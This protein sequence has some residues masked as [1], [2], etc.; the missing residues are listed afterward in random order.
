M[1]FFV[2]AVARIGFEREVYVTR[3]GATEEVCAI[4]MAPPTLARTVVVNLQSYDGSAIG[5]LTDSGTCG[6]QD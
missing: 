5:R 3:E 6:Q 2:F 4:L 1:I